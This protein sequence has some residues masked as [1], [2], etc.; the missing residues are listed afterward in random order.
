MIEKNE[1]E[2][3]GE[4]IVHGPDESLRKKT[5]CEKCRYPLYGNRLM[6]VFGFREYEKAAAKMK[7]PE[8][9]ILKLNNTP[10]RNLRSLADIVVY[11]AKLS[12][13]D[14]RLKILDLKC[15][16]PELSNRCLVLFG[17]PNL[18]RMSSVFHISQSLLGNLN[19]GQ[20]SPAMTTLMKIVINLAEHSTE[21]QRVAFCGNTWLYFD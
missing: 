20:G 10:G 19:R 14:M 5:A 6:R 18:A 17:L 13:P 11:F 21:S 2:I 1:C 16:W 4:K 3:C 7:L 15:T 12:E 9:I 8:K